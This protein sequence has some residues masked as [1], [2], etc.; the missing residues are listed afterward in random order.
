MV[1]T[2]TD[3]MQTKSVNYQSFHALTVKMIQDQ[4][5]EIQNL[6]ALLEKRQLQI[7]ELKSLIQENLKK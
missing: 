4:E 2:A 7:E 3:D 5:A 1:S 6:K